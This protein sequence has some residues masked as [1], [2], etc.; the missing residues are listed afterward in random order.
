MRFITRLKKLVGISIYE[1]S[2]QYAQTLTIG[3][4]TALSQRMITKFSPDCRPNRITVGRD[5]CLVTTQAPCLTGDRLKKIS[6]LTL[7]PDLVEI[8][9]IKLDGNPIWP[10]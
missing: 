5:F 6:E 10:A 8:K 9:E 7:A 1:Y 2:I 4:V 3:Q